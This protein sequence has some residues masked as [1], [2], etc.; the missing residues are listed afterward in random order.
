[1]VPGQIKGLHEAWQR[2][3]KLN[4]TELLEPSIDIARDGFR[5]TKAIENAIKA[6]Q[7]TLE[8]NRFAEL[9]Y[10]NN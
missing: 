2:Y 7:Q 10:S 4:W 3:G 8:N 5:V 9:R 6:I 1:M